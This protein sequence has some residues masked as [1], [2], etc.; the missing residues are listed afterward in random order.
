MSLLGLPYC[1]DRWYDDIIR[2]RIS[3]QIHLLSGLNTHNETTVRVSTDE[4]SL[5]LASPASQYMRDPEKAIKS[6]I[7]LK[8]DEHPTATRGGQRTQ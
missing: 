2:S 3:V 6:C 8:M 1:I 7:V 4:K 5:V